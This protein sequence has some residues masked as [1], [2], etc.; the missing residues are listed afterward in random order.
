MKPQKEDCY[1]S[2]ISE[3]TIV[4]AMIVKEMIVGAMI[5]GAMIVGEMIVGAMIVGARR[6]SRVYKLLQ[7][8][9]P[10]PPSV[11]SWIR[12]W[13]VTLHTVPMLGH[14]LQRWPSKK[15]ALSHF[16]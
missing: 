1:L 14:R 11:N 9:A 13:V 3:K 2:E 10:P 8:S 7:K 6:L 16:V 5:V 15:P 4:G 12:H